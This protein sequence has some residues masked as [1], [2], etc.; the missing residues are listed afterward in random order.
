MPGKLGTCLAVDVDGCGA[1]GVP[2]TLGLLYQ[3]AAAPDASACW[4]CEAV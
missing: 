4:V 2:F 1:V 3:A